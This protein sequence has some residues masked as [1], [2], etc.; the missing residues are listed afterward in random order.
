MRL[1]WLTVTCGCS[2]L[3]VTPPPTK[4]T[5]VHVGAA[6]AVPGETMEF[7][8][9]LRGI[10]IG[11]VQTAVGKPGW[12]DGKRAIIVKSRGHT[13]GLLSVIGDLG[14]ELTTTIGLDDGVPLEDHEEAWASLG[15]NHEHERDD[16]TW[17]ADDHHHDIHSAVTAVRGWRSEPGQET[18]LEVVIGRGRL[19]VGLAPAGR[20]YLAS[21]K[22]P[23][24][25]YDGVV[26]DKLRF[27]TWVS[28][29][30]QR[31]PLRLETESELGTIAVELVDYQAPAE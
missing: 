17:S 7:R 19:H 27:V 28:D 23:A 9:K 18:E 2:A 4:P 31:A 26:D 20:E 5:V 30:T 25:R 14:W 8:V 3:P 29:D 1:V 16:H 11:L 24:V 15:G 13:D 12:T 22:S 10:A 6:L 21:A